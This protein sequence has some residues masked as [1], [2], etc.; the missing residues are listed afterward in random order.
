MCCAK[1]GLLGPPVS[2]QIRIFLRAETK[3]N[4]KKANQVFVMVY[5]SKAK[6]MEMSKALV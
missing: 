1:S 6:M 3:Y 4:K 5:Y 2:R